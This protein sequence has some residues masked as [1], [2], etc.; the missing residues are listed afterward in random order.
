MLHFSG[1]FITATEEGFK[2]LYMTEN[3][4]TK[5]KASYVHVSVSYLR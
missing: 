3:Q 5:R 2:I 4:E 1:Y